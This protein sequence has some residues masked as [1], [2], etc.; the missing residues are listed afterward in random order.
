MDGG[1][2][3]LCTL[4]DNDLDRNPF[5]QINLC[6]KGG[7][8]EL[9]HLKQYL[10][11]HFKFSFLCFMIGASYMQEKS[12]IGFLY[13]HVVSQPISDKMFQENEFVKIQSI[14]F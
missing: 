9:G 10:V 14:F 5:Y 7:I 12:S 2:C 8:K 6:V 13:S 3:N 1:F 4:P 11:G